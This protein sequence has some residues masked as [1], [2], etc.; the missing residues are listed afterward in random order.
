MNQPTVKYLRSQYG[1]YYEDATLHLPP[2][3]NQREWGYI[4][5]TVD[6][7]TRM[8]RH[9]S[10]INHDD[11][12]TFFAGKQPKHVY[13]SAAE[14]T[15]P[16]QNDMDDKGWIGAD[17]IFDIDSP[18][19]PSA[20]EDDTYAETLEKGKQETKALLDILDRDF[21]FTDLTLVFS[22]GK[23]YHVHVRDEG[24][25]ELGR[26]ARKDVVRYVLG[27]GVSVDSMTYVKNGQYEHLQTD[28]GWGRRIHEQFMDLVASLREMD[29]ETAIETLTEYGGV[30]ESRAETLVDNLDDWTESFTEAN[31]SKRPIRSVIEGMK[32]EVV[33]EQGAAIDEPVTTDIR[34][35]IRLPGS[36]HGGTGLRVTPIPIDDVDAF[37]PLEDAV[38]DLYGTDSV[39]VT[40][41]DDCEF[42]FKGEQHSF[43]PPENLELPNDMAIYMM[44]KE[45]AVHGYLDPDLV[46]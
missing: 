40:I 29:D 9:I 44:T 2:N 32:D 19:I 23:G 3:A 8:K 17:L 30:G 22:G 38:P 1:D 16:S 7:K 46:M 20:D 34:R 27:E 45:Y 28:G 36:L 31:L 35:L 10:L 15:A 24:V 21:G 33:Q 39:E 37:D 13:F 26:D 14:Y 42:E 4:P 43:S 11:K 41:V 5:W 18:Q 12:N 6:G 25:A